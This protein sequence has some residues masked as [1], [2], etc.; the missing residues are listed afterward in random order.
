MV[1]LLQLCLKLRIIY[2]HCERRLAAPPQPVDLGLAMAHEAFSVLWYV[3]GLGAAMGNRVCL[4]VSTPRQ[5]EN[6]EPLTKVGLPT[7][8]IV[9]DGFVGRG[10]EGISF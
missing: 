7:T 2:S 5:H 3:N 9:P 1:E 6:F 8:E 10:R 4:G